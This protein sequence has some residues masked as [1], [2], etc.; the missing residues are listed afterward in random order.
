MMY[1][2]MIAMSVLLATGCSGSSEDLLTKAAVE[3][4]FHGLS[5]G[6]VSSIPLADDVHFVGPTAPGGIRGEAAVRSFLAETAAGLETMVLKRLFVDG[7]YACA[8][9][10]LKVRTLDVPPISGVDCFRVIDG[11]IVEVQPYF[12][13]TPL[14]SD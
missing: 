5:T 7:E 11:K 3:D 8:P 12:D 2:E 13:P 6:D 4:Y 10:E 14:V 9:F 1:R